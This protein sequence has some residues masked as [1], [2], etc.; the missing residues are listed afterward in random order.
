MYICICRYRIYV[1]LYPIKFRFFGP[2]M[3][4]PTL[5]PGQFDS[6]GGCRALSVGPEKH[7]VHLGSLIRNMTEMWSCVKG[8]KVFIDNMYIYIYTYV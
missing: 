4:T 8:T 7:W 6:P 3:Y 5:G 2:Q 1:A